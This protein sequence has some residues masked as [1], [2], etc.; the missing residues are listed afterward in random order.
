MNTV[1][2]KTNRTSNNE[3][4]ARDLEGV[5]SPLQREA[6]YSLMIKDGL[7]RIIRGGEIVG[8]AGVFTSDASIRLTVENIINHPEWRR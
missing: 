2:P 8:N 4:F 5:L 3:Y 7:I 1:Y 6:G